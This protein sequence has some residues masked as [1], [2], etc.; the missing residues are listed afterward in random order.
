MVRVGAIARVAAAARASTV[1]R[2]RLV[3]RE[4]DAAVAQSA[5]LSLLNCSRTLYL[6]DHNAPPVSE[7]STTNTVSGAS[8]V[9]VSAAFQRAPAW[10]PS[11]GP[12]GKGLSPYQ[13]FV[14]SQSSPEY[15]ARHVAIAP[16][17]PMAT[18]ASW[19]IFPPQSSTQRRAAAAWAWA[20]GQTVTITA[21]GDVRQKSAAVR[22]AVI[23]ALRR[24]GRRRAVE[25]NALA[26]PSSGS[27]RAMRSLYGI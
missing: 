7:A 1:E 19:S 11:G 4:V 25:L 12:S 5:D 27:R 8:C 21:C 26:Q 16:C 3:V 10:G 24:V 20:V 22:S 6:L 9:Q 14:S 23:T 15:R 2:R 18:S 17:L 13:Q